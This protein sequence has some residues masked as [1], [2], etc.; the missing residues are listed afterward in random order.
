MI[1]GYCRVSTHGQADYGNGLDVQMAQVRAAGATDVRC[2]SYTGTTMDRPVWNELVSTVA[3]GDT[4][5]VAKLDRIARTASEG[6]HAVKEL[7]DRGVSVHI[8]NMG[9]ADSTPMGK[10]LL[11]I[12]FAFAE[13][14]RDQL[15]ERMASGKE[16]ARTRPGYREGRRPKRISQRELASAVADERDGLIT[17]TQAAERLGVSRRTYCRRRDALTA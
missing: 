7:L 8:L 12:M 10:L 15:V 14:D 2:E 11:N 17:A 5:V 1:Y 16:V 13:F 4:I 6:T 9:M 3:D